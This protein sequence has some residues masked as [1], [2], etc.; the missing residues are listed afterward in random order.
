M[1]EAMIDNLIE[2]ENI[3]LATAVLRSNHL[4]VQSPRLQTINHDTLLRD[5]NRDDFPDGIAIA[6]AEFVITKFNLP[7]TGDHRIIF[8][9]REL[10]IPKSKKPI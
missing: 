1:S 5:Y 7:Y 3:L 6:E 8:P 10:K 9:E 2:K 4:P